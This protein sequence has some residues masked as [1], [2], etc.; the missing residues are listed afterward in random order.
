MKK[1]VA[2]AGVIVAVVGGVLRLLFH[3]WDLFTL[4]FTVTLGF[5]G[6]IIGLIGV[7]LLIYGLIA[8]GPKE[9]AQLPNETFI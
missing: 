3:G 8:K 5:I 4:G 6:D 9:K 2:V 1:I 7:I